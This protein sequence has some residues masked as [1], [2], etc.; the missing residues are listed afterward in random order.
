MPETIKGT[1]FLLALV[2]CASLMPVETLPVASWQTAMVLG[3]VS[4]VFDNI[5]LTALA[6]PRADADVNFELWRRGV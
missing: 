6:V 5:P 1:T 4:A 3:F 2:I